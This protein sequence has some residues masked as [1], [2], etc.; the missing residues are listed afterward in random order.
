MTDTQYHT[1]YEKLRRLGYH[2]NDYYSSHLMPQIPWIIKNIPFKNVLDVGSSS[3]GAIGV[4]QVFRPEI[5]IFGI[6]ISLIAARSG[7]SFDR[8]IVCGS[9]INLPYKDKSFDLVIS[10]DC[11]EHLDTEDINQMIKEIVRVTKGYV[12]IQISERSDTA[13]W[14]NIVGEPLH[15]TIK[16][17]KWWINKF[18]NAWTFPKVIKINTEKSSFCMAVE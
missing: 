6:D 7:L 1:L 2:Q 12:F 17:L 16:P 3:G 10:S 13:A 9:A 5:D 8:N 18:F 14:K 15:K 4:L 11:L